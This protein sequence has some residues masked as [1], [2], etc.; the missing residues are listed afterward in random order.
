MYMIVFSSPLQGMGLLT[1]LLDKVAPQHLVHF[2]PFPECEPFSTLIAKQVELRQE[3]GVATLTDEIDRFL[4]VGQQCPQAT[5]TEA[6]AFLQ[7]LLHSSK[8]EL[9]SLVKQGEA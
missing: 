5:R 3:V 4:T 6:L 8:L 7:K 2:D 1:Y 9:A